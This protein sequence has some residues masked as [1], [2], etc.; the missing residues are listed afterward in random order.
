VGLNRVIKHRL[1]QNQIQY[2]VDSHQQ[3]MKSGLTADQVKFTTS[4]PVLRDV[5][6]AGVVSVYEI[7][8][9]LFGR[10]LVQKVCLFHLLL[11]YSDISLQSWARC[12]VK[13]WDLSAECLTSSQAQTA[14]VDYLRT[15]S[16][17]HE[18]IKDRMGVIHGLDEIGSA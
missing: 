11:H 6:V 2:L 18:E 3:Q 15:H 12:Q 16:A 10:E 14:L 17:L 1:K 9:G 7:M 8:T 13:G 5:L 4:L